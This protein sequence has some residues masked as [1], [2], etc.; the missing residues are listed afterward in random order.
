[1]PLS[2]TAGTLP[3]PVPRTNWPGSKATFQF[4]DNELVIPW[5]TYMAKATIHVPSEIQLEHD[6][7]LLLTLS[8]VMLVTTRGLVIET[9]EVRSNRR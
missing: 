3:T 6:L 4:G 7:L 2:Y 9:A 1:M 5:A 8:Q